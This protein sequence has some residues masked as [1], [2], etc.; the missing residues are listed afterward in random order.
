MITTGAPTDMAIF[1]ATSF[2]IR[3]AMLPQKYETIG[4]VAQNSKNLPTLEG[5][6]GNGIL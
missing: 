1:L 3:L 2:M 4:N 6:P 5:I